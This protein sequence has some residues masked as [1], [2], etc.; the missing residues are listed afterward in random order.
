MKLWRRF[1]GNI[2]R[3]V[4]AEGLGWLA[5]GFVRRQL[6]ALLA[7]GPALVAMPLLRDGAVKSV[8]VW[9]SF[10]LWAVWNVLT[11]ALG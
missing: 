5:G 9:S 7:L 8:I 11:L 6:V 1:V 3:E 2:K 4:I 10:G